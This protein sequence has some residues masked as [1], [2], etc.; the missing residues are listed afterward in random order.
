MKPPALWLMRGFAIAAVA[1]LLLFFRAIAQGRQGLFFGAAASLCVSVTAL[2]VTPVAVT[3][4]FARRAELHP[5]FRRIRTAALMGATILALL[6]AVWLFHAPPALAQWL[7][8]AWVVMG[9]TGLAIWLTTGA[10]A[11]LAPHDTA[12]AYPG[13]LAIAL[14]FGLVV[15][16]FVMKF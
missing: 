7:G 5:L 1:S 10:K 16:S 8:L 11:R 2:L 13:P 6:G 15:A 3:A 4:Q 9:L 14:I 12:I